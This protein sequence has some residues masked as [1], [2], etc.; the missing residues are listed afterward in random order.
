MPPFLLKKRY[1]HHLTHVKK[2]KDNSSDEYFINEPM[3]SNL[4]STFKDE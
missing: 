2:I 1:L 3:W 4:R